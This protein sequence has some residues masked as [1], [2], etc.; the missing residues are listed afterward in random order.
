MISLQIARHEVEV[1]SP[2]HSARPKRITASSAGL[3]TGNGDAAIK[4]A[5]NATA[6]MALAVNFIAKTLVFY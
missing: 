4:I 2:V 1:A 5:R 3:G 6:N